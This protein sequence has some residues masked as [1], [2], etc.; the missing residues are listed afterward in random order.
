[1]SAPE[2]ILGMA[3]IPAAQPKQVGRL[4]QLFGRAVSAQ[5]LSAAASGGFVQSIPEVGTF[6][7]LA[8][9]A[10]TRCWNPELTYANDLK[11]RGQIASGAAAAQLVLAFVPLGLEGIFEGQLPYHEWLMLESNRFRCAGT[12]RINVSGGRVHVTCDDDAFEFELRDGLWRDL[13]TNSA[14]VARGKSQLIYISGY[15]IDPEILIPEDRTLDSANVAAAYRSLDQ[16]FD[17]VTRGG[18]DCSDWVRRVI[19]RVSIVNSEGGSRLSSRSLA[20]R[21]GNI[22]MAAPGDHLHIAELLVH[23]A[24]HQHFALGRL[25]GAFVRPEVDR[26]LFYSAINQRQRPLERV[27]LAYH[28]VANIFE[29]LDRLITA[30]DSLGPDAIERMIDMG[31]TEHSLRHTLLDAWDDLTAFGKSFSER[32]IDHG[33]SIVQRHNIPAERAEPKVVWGGE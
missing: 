32:M 26:K 14:P 10:G 1:M 17:A 25:Y 27:A 13:A 5:L 33:Q 15:S 30:N 3:T 22:E 29:L 16:A 8:D 21:A 4:C 23:E 28:A 7:A 9:G 31:K 11:R 24:A 19:A 18:E 2:A 12:I 6:E 20:S